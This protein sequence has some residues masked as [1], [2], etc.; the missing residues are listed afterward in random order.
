MSDRLPEGTPPRARKAPS[1][2]S[3]RIW[4]NGDGVEIFRDGVQIHDAGSLLCVVP[5][6]DVPLVAKLLAEVQP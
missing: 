2:R 1:G 3:Y 5:L 6:I 4:A